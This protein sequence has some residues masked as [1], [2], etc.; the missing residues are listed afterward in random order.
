LLVAALM[1]KAAYRLLKDSGRVLLEMAP[2]Q[3]NV[4]E[5]GD[6]LAAHPDVASVHDLHVLEI[7]SDFPSLPAHVLVHKGDDCHAIRMQ[8]ERL[9]DERFGIDHTTLQVDH[10]SSELVQIGTPSHSAD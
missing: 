1:L 5:I 10:E 7:G 8:L 3:L 9:L 2:E 4:Q 6:A